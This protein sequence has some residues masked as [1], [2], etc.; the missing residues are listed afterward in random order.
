[1]MPRMSG[2]E[3]LKELVK[4][5][6]YVNRYRNGF[7]DRRSNAGGNRSFYKGDCQEAVQ[8]IRAEKGNSHCYIVKMASPDRFTTC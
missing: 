2:L 6:P 1:M 5:H 7:F 8:D 4:I 3:C